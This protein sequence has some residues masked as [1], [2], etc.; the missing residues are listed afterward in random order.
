MSDENWTEVSPKAIDIKKEKDKVYEGQFVDARK[1]E[2]KIGEQTI[3]NFT[4]FSIYGFTTFNSKMRNIAPGTRC[5]IMY[6]GKEP[7]MTQKFGMKDVHQVSVKT[8]KGKE[9]NDI[10]F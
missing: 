2:T 4:E 1:I 9:V 8:L 6:T 7:M 5:R 3:W 10:P